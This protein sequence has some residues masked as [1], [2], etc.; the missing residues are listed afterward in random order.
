MEIVP[1]LST[2]ILVGTI[3]TFV[4]A[5]AAYI[6][7]KLR[8]RRGRGR[9]AGQVLAHEP[10]REPH[11]LVTP[12]AHPGLSMPTGQAAHASMFMAPTSTVPPV[13]PP[14]ELQ[15]HHGWPPLAAPYPEPAYSEAGMRPTTPAR[16]DHPYRVPEEAPRH[17][18]AAAPNEA[19]RAGSSMFMEYTDHGFV[20]FDAVRSRHPGGRH[21]V[22]PERE[23]PR[24]DED[25][26][27]AWL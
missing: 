10:L 7:Y 22:P 21:Q 18:T 14:P 26:E 15:Q 13:G 19:A 6:L 17:R 16:H 9:R 4:L 20:P 3:A 23:A 11:V 25:G 2:I 27:F 12:T 5:V 8:E 1:I 24:E